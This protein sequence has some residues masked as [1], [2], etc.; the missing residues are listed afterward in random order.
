MLIYDKN[1]L[2]WSMLTC[3]DPSLGRCWVEVTQLHDY[4]T[5]DNELHHS[6]LCCGEPYGTSIYSTLEDYT[7]SI[8]MFNLVKGSELPCKSQ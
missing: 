1:K 4:I 8:I 6:L 7:N 5:F 3:L 2:V